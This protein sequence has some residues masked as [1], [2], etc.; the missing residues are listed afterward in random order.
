[1]SFRQ[2]WAIVCVS[3]VRGALQTG[4]ELASA[5]NQP[6]AFPHGSH[7]VFL[8]ERHVSMKKKPVSTSRPVVTKP[9]STVVVPFKI[10]TSYLFRTIGYHWV[11]CVKAICGQFLILSSASWV[12]DTG[13]YSDATKG[14]L[15]ESSSSE[16]EPAAADV[17]LN[18]E[19]ITD[20]TEYPF[21]LPEIQ[22]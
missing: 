17:I 11:G 3:V 14:K 2:T 6:G 5:D 1:M 8:F 12:A 20:A 19:H 10:G 21:S 16:I 15:L 7:R 9:K 13:R 22:K 18:Y 4:S